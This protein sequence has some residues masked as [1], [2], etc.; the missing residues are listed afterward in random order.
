M[1]HDQVVQV[2]DSTSLSA[3]LFVPWSIVQIVL[4]RADL[5][6]V[7]VRR[8]GSVGANSV[9]SFLWGIVVCGALKNVILAKIN[10]TLFLNPLLFSIHF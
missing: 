2:H 1:G 3:Y 9:S 6:G 10:P 8:L 7:I 4:N 5:W